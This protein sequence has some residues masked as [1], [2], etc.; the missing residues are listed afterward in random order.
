MTR[1]NTAAGP[2]PPEK[3]L[4]LRGGG[5]TPWSSKLFLREGDAG[6]VARGGVWMPG[7]TPGLQSQ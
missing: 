5:V 7:G 6:K 4:L 2:G 1:S 3:P